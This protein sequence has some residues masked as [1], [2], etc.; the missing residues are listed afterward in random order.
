MTITIFHFVN[1]YLKEQDYVIPITHMIKDEV[2]SFKAR[3]FV[4]GLKRWSDEQCWL[5]SECDL[6]ILFFQHISKDSDKS[7][8]D[9]HLTCLERSFQSYLINV[10]ALQLR[11]FHIKVLH[12]LS[13]YENNNEDIS[14]KLI[15]KQSLLELP[16]FFPKTNLLN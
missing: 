11:A 13:A 9:Q 4:K 12:L 6:R 2:I 5:V 15:V 8:D 3:I 10:Y 7:A 14:N 16:V 1:C